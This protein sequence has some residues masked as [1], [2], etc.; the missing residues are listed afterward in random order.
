MP[1][2]MQCS[3][4]SAFIRQNRN[5]ILYFNMTHY[6]VMRIAS[7]VILS[8]LCAKQTAWL[9]TDTETIF[10]NCDFIIYFFFVLS[11]PFQWKNYYV[12]QLYTII[13]WFFFHQKLYKLIR[14]MSMHKSYLFGKTGI[15]FFILTWPIIG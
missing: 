7:W 11:Y 14:F 10:K 13:L 4:R 6:W 15:L 1:E 9:F 12:N 8:N 5:I 2:I 3:T